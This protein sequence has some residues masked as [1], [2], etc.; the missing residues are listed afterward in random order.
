MNDLITEVENHM[1]QTAPPSKRPARP[2]AP[3]KPL[4]KATIQELADTT[5]MS[6]NSSTADIDNDTMARIRKCLDRA[7]HPN[8]LE[9]EAKSSTSRCIALDGAI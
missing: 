7:K 8:S 6:A 4:Y 5:Y 3:P 2:R 9:A 1:A